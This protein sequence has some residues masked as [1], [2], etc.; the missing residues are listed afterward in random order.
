MLNRLKALES[1]CG[2][3]ESNRAIIAKA[4]NQSSWL[5]YLLICY[6]LLNVAVNIYLLI[7]V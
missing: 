4:Q 6:L 2:S 1:I 5:T 7:K 3:N